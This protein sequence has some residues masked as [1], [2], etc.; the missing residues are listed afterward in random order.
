M[1][2]LMEHIRFSRT[3][4]ERIKS[5]IALQCSGEFLMYCYR[6]LQN[7]FNIPALWTIKGEI[8]RTPE[9]IC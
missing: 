4:P 7:D 2:C 9:S 6:Y 3:I 1:L 8:T 5:E